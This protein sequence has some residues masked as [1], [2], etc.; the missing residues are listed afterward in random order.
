[1]GNIISLLGMGKKV[2]LREG[3]THKR[4]L[5]SMGLKTFAIKE[6]NLELLDSYSAERNVSLI[7]KKFSTQE[8]VQYLPGHK[9]L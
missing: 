3:T 2:F 6:M 1:M 5:D 4:F 9:L 7:R 8:L